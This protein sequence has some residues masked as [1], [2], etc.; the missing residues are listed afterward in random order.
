MLLMRMCHSI[1]SD[2][3][4]SWS[5]PCHLTH[6]GVDAAVEASLPLEEGVANA[7]ALQNSSPAAEDISH[8]W[9][10]GIAA[11]RGRLSSLAAQASHRQWLESHTD[12]WVTPNRVLHSC[13]SRIIAD[14]QGAQQLFTNK[15]TLCKIVTYLQMQVKWVCLEP[16]AM[17]DRWNH[18]ST[19][20]VSSNQCPIFSPWVM[21]SFLQ[22]IQGSRLCSNWAANVSRCLGVLVEQKREIAL[23]FPSRDLDV[24]HRQ[25]QVRSSTHPALTQGIWSHCSDYNTLRK[26]IA[27]RRSTHS[28]LVIWVW[29]PVILVACSD[30]YAAR[31]L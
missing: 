17:I 30:C 28:T 18:Q 14:L 29:K 22:S 6:T 27:F 2:T 19:N 10:P 13:G 26:L 1:T 4:V 9:H 20:Q 23:C 5:T 3:S 12:I 11:V 25:I 15:I 16:L 24:M 31:A 21:P 7:S 8:D